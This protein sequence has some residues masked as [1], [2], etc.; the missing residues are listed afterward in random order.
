VGSDKSY[1]YVSETVKVL[2]EKRGV[3][4]LVLS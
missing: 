4:A 3:K 2:R 1:C